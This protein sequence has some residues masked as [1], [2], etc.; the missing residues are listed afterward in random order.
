[1]HLKYQKITSYK[2]I[3]EYVIVIDV[4]YLNSI[5]NNL[6]YLTLRCHLTNLIN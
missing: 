2:E 4:F 6:K 5:I 1:M 3:V